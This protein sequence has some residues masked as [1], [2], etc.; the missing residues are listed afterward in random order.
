MKYFCKLALGISIL[1]YLHSYALGAETFKIGV[2]DIQAF[3]KKSVAVRKAKA[4]LKTKFDAM[5]KKLE[6]EKDNL[7]KFEEDFRKQSMML[8][9]DAKEGKKR[10]LEKKRRFYK[11]LYEDFSQDMKGEEVEVTKR[12]GKQLEKVVEKIGEKGKYTVIL[13]KR[14]LGLVYY[15]DAIDITDQVVETYDR[16]AR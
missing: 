6:K 8:S 16:S 5:Q 14:T 10:E 2:V 7:R 11:Y 15:D 4:Q 9:L 12:I 3:Q 1:F 13:E